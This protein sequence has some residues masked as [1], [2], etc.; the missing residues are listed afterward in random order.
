MA[1]QPALAAHIDVE[2]LR[3]SLVNDNLRRW[4]AATRSETGL[5]A[6]NLDRA[7]QSAGE[8]H[9]T[10]VSQ[11][12]S[13]YVLAMGHDLTGEM[14]FLAGVRA[15]ADAM[16]ACFADTEHGGFFETVDAQ[17]KPLAPDTAPKQSY[18]HA[19]AIF[20]LAHAHRV[21]GESRYLEAARDAV[22]AVAR[23]KDEA[24]GLRPHASRDWSEVSGQRA[25]NETMHLL[26]ALLALHDASG[27]PWIRREVDKLLEFT[28]AHMWL[29]DRG[30]L[31]RFMGEDWRPIGA[32]REDATVNVGHQFEWA[33]LLDWV[34]ACG[35]D[36]TWLAKGER[37]LDF[38]LAA[39][40][41]G[42][43]DRPHAV[44][45]WSRYDRSPCGEEVRLWWP[46]VEFLRAA[47][48][49]ATRHGRD[50]LWPRFDQVLAMV[51]RHLIDAE[52][53]GWFISFD[54]AAPDERS[55]AD[56][57]KGRA[58]KRGYHETVM[59]RQILERVGAV[60]PARQMRHASA[61]QRARAI[62]GR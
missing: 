30:C 21:T 59:Y 6:V 33:A 51:R 5:A 49:Y 23:F 34:A 60:K 27:L 47:A 11:G 62:P 7:W 25:E 3:D 41:G 48:T 19:F 9:A 22:A 38:G 1:D 55:E 52:H 15:M 61:G 53:G 20:G 18:G 10:L 24:G 50:D 35:M 37:M 54:P 17:G 43:E 26:E 32:E 4:L 14:G 58:N 56:A 31:P 16:L 40:F 29:E 46:Q 36:R 42:L 45:T 39:G 28:F 8:Q 57:F 12:R 44:R 13:I 2:W